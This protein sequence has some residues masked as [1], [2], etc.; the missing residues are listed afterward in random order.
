MTNVMG[1]S[2][3]TLKEAASMYGYE[4][5]RAFWKILDKLSCPKIQPCGVGGCI[6]FPAIPFEQWLAKE[7][8]NQK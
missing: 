1:T 2:C 8:N 6:Y 4:N 5:Y 7:R 3:Y